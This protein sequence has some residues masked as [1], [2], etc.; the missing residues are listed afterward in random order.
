[1]LFYHLVVV[2]VFTAYLCYSHLNVHGRS[3][4]FLSFCGR[5]TS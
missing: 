5:L 1:M 3:T 2:L 4:F